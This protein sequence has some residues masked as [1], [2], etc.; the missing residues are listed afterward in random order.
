V[1]TGQYLNRRIDDIAV[2]RQEEK[3]YFEEDVIV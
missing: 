1:L 2:V 3:Q